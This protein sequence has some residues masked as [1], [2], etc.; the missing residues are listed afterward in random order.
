MPVTQPKDLDYLLD[1]LLLARRPF[2]AADVLQSQMS[3]LPVH[4]ERILE[5]LEAGFDADRNNENAKLL[6]AYAI[7][8][9]IRHLQENYRDDLVRI[10]RIEWVYLPVL[11][12]YTSVVRP[13]TLLNE[14]SKSP[15]VYMDLIKAVY[16]SE[17][18]ATSKV[19]ATENERLHA[20]RALELL[21]EFSTLPGIRPG[22]AIDVSLL[23]DWVMEV[24]RLASECGRRAI[25]DLQVGELLS[26]AP[27]ER[28][29]DW[30][31]MA[32]RQLLED[33]G[34][35]EVLRGF[36]SGIYNS[37]GI[38]GRDPR[39]GGDPERALAEQFK[40][41]ADNCRSRFP[42]LA[43]KIRNLAD[44][45]MQSAKEEDESAIRR[46]LNR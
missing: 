29:S 12:R 45:Y 2:Y 25:T 30:P 4:C 40:S 44:S 9:L 32:I 21:E 39:N 20:R 16:R 8:Q 6:D 38:V 15:A 37:R 41:I 43:Q 26:N 46:R 24:R 17:N 3:K 34:T 35:D 1:H 42:K 33:I 22:K 14:L 10:A 36:T 13:Q 19:T 31:E 11:D 18:E 7:Q 5:V 27:G 28:T 23:R